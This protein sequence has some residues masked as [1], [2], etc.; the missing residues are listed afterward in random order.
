MSSK[1][2]RSFLTLFGTL[3]G[4]C[5]WTLMIVLTTQ[6]A[7]K[8]PKKSDFLNLY[9][10]AKILQEYGTSELYNTNA[11]LTI[12]NELLGSNRG[13][14]IMAFRS[15]PVTAALYFP[16]AYL[17][18][19]TAYFINYSISIAILLAVTIF[20]IKNEKLA[21]KHQATIFSLVFASGLYLFYN[22]NSLLILL[23]VFLIYDALLK[24]K[25]GLAGLLCSFLL[26]KTQHILLAPFVFILIQNKKEFSKNFFLGV[27]VII[28]LSYLLY[29]SGFVPDYL[30]FT[31]QTE[32]TQFGTPNFQNVNLLGTINRLSPDTNLYSAK[33]LVLNLLFLVEALIA[34]FSKNQNEQI[35]KIAFAAAVIFSL[36]FN[37]HTLSPDLVVLVIPAIILYSI[38]TRLRGSKRLVLLLTSFITIVTFSTRTD[39][40]HLQVDTLLNLGLLAGAFS[41]LYIGKK[42]L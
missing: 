39:L 28:A 21:I 20:A 40:Q 7:A 15:L 29:G 25:S 3:V 41:A 27:L 42:G 35:K 5:L 8:D 2:N 30:V 22:Q 24:N 34:T 4:V 6:D 33:S 23:L 10:G 19:D 26:I 11:Q 17:N 9:T 37:L 31:L 1:L 14:Y 13:E 32:T 38:A 18:F 12:Q 36:Q 16:Y